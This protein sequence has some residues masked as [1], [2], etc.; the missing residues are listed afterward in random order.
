M[1][2]KLE[3]FWEKLEL[4]WNALLELLVNYLLWPIGSFGWY[5]YH[6]RT[7]QYRRARPFYNR[8]LLGALAIVCMVFGGVIF[9]RYEAPPDLICVG[10]VLYI[11]G[12]YCHYTAFD[13]PFPDDGI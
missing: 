8:I 6:R 4:C 13:V 5:H 2:T 12:W 1:K 9:Y 10:I 11:V 7:G 3:L